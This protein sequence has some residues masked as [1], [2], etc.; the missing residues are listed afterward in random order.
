MFYSAGAALG[1][2]SAGLLFTLGPYALSPWIMGAATV[3]YWKAGWEDMQQKRHTIRRNF[4]VLGRVRYVLEMLR[5]EIRQYFIEGDKEMLPFSREQRS[6]VYSRAKGQVD[7][8]PLGTRRDVYLEGYEWTLHS[9]FPTHVTEAD[10]R[11]LI[12][13]PECKQPYSAS[14]LNVSAMSYGALSDNAILALNSGA[15]MGG[16]CHNTGEG[17]MSKFHLL[18]GGDICF[19]IGTGYF[20]CRNNDTGGFDPEKFKAAAARPQVK[21]IEIKLSQG[22]KP[23]HGGILPAAKISPAI[24]EARGIPSDRDCNSPPHHAEFST[25]RGLLDFVARLRVLSDGKPIGVKLCVGHPAELAAVV[26][27]MVETGI[28]PDFITVDGAEGGTG[29]APPEFSNSVGMPLV[30]ALVLVHQLLIG[31]GLRQ[32]IKIISS[33]KVLSGFSLVRNLALGADACNSAR[34]MMF[35]LGCIQALKCNTNKCPSGVATQDPE[36]MKGLVVE[37]KATRVHNYHKA[38]IHAACEIMS[39]IGVNKPSELHP[40]HVMRRIS[41]VHVSTYADLFPPV[42]PGALINGSG[43]ELLQEYYAMGKMVYENGGKL[44][45]ISSSARSLATAPLAR[46]SAA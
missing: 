9:M 35:A 4:P 40:S 41:G 15:K 21:M 11:T 23:S 33:G 19:Q 17:G 36:L 24:A 3:W 8:M 31:T 37:D 12:G 25:P 26:H 10:A 5:P 14:L 39:A 43:P 16:F 32:D 2:G 13:G 7:T 28:K 20:G 44:P 30:E 45:V 42:Q 22:A 18:P 1:A 34:A 6:I 38:T 46:A 29:A 27:A